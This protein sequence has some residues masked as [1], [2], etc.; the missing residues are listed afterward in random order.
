MKVLQFLWL[1]ARIIDYSGPAESLLRHH[2]APRNKRCFRIPF[3][4]NSAMKS[5][6]ISASLSKKHNDYLIQGLFIVNLN[7]DSCFLSK[8]SYFNAFHSVR[9]DRN[10]VQDG[11]WK[12]ADVTA[13]NQEICKFT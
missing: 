3:W 2:N 1:R 8:L 11:I 10:N 4:A 6:N 13:V 7:T 9:I 12:E 5:P